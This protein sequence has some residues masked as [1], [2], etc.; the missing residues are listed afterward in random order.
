MKTVD[1]EVYVIYGNLIDPNGEISIYGIYEDFYLAK[2]KYDE[3]QAQNHGGYLTSRYVKAVMSAEELPREMT[4]EFQQFLEEFELTSFL[5]RGY[6]R[7]LLIA[8][9]LSKRVPALKTFEDFDA[10]AEV[11]ESKELDHDIDYYMYNKALEKVLG[12]PV[13]DDEDE[14]ED[15]WDKINC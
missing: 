15:F 9:E 14:D 3:L 10:Y 5:G 1:K 6:N 11:L 4:P 8:Y 13:F 2:E 12:H 7:D